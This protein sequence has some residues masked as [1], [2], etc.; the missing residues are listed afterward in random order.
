MG[1]HGG[2]GVAPFV[3]APLAVKA[4]AI[5]ALASGAGGGHRVAHGGWT[6]CQLRAFALWRAP[7]GQGSGRSSRWVAWPGPRAGESLGRALAAAEAAAAQNS[8][9]RGANNCK[10]CAGFFKKNRW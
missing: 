6:W 4:A 10:L 9:R 8:P 7:G 5:V 3:G 2:G 1:M